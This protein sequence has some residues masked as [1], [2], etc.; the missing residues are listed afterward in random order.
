LADELG[1]SLTTLALSFNYSRWFSASTI[2][3]A[4]SMQQLEENIASMEFKWT[5]EV[6]SGIEQIHLNFFNPAP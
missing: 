3:G 5:D 2:I 4:T 6:E 1:I